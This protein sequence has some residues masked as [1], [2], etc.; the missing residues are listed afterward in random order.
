M[1]ATVGGNLWEFCINLRQENFVFLTNQ[2]PGL[3]SRDGAPAN[4]R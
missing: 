4:H 2:N 3:R 1:N